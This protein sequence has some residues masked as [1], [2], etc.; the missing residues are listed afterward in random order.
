MSI[1]DKCR[2]KKQKFLD[3]QVLFSGD[4]QIEK[5]NPSVGVAKS[6]GGPSEAELKV[7]NQDGRSRRKSFDCF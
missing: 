6:I 7:Y 4:A 5:L 1:D 3:N 2:S